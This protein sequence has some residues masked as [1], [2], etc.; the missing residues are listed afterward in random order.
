MHQ[1]SPLKKFE[2]DESYNTVKLCLSIDITLTYDKIR[3][4]IEHVRT[5]FTVCYN[6][7]SPRVKYH[8]P[9]NNM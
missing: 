3:T 2:E 7:L 8:R 5:Y 9:I 6:L 1:R 4:K